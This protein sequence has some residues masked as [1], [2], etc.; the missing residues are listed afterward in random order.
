MKIDE[1][2]R[3]CSRCRQYQPIFEYRGLTETYE[4]TF[5]N[6]CAYCG[7]NN[8]LKDRRL[9]QVVIFRRDSEKGA[10]IMLSQRIHPEKPY[11]GIMQGTGEKIDIYTDNYGQETLETEE[12][13]AMREILEES[14]I[15]LE[16]EKL[17]KIWSETVPSQ[18][19][20]TARRCE[21]QDATYNEVIFM[22]L[23]PMLQKNQDFI[24]QEIGKYFNYCE[25]ESLDEQEE[26]DISQ[27][28]EKEFN[29]F[30]KKTEKVT[31]K[32][33]IAIEKYKKGI[34]L[35]INRLRGRLTRVN[36]YLNNYYG[37]KYLQIFDFQ[38]RNKVAEKVN[39]LPTLEEIRHNA[40]TEYSKI[41]NNVYRY[42][43]HETGDKK[44]ILRQLKI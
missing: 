22:N 33:I 4:M 36:K 18:L 27:L 3:Q 38:D 12:D 41:Q 20:W 13:A 6:N 23:I 7:S 8:Q 25:I 31:T 39:C 21:T 40:P 14:G 5:Y 10:Q 16:E 43:V 19:E 24:F 34:T 2:T 28:T 1:R 30:K 32:E 29:S 35:K 15:I 9:V 26:N 11:L 37:R 44:N 42:T 17:Q